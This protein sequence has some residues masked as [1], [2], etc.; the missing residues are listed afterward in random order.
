VVEAGT[1][2]EKNPKRAR[3]SQLI[4]AMGDTDVGDVTNDGAFASY[5]KDKPGMATLVQGVVDSDMVSNIFS[6]AADG[7]GIQ[8]SPAKSS[9]KGGAAAGSPGENGTPVKQEPSERLGMRPFDDVADVEEVQTV[10]GSQL[11]KIV[12]NFASLEKDSQL[13]IDSI[14]D[15]QTYG[16]SFKHLKRR[17]STLRAIQSDDLQLKS[18][19]QKLLENKSTDALPIPE[20]FLAKMVAIETLQER[21][22]ALNCKSFDD[23]AREQKVFE[24][25]FRVL[26]LLH[27]AVN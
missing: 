27:G 7:M 11:S 17:V 15:D 21:L 22:M 5:T 6:A 25:D 3:L 13:L 24:A 1:A 9:K 18:H 2:Q 10:L 23:L 14:G 12:N 16:E 8:P 19:I 20:D 4:D 26:N